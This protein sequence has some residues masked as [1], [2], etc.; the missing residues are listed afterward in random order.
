TGAIYIASPAA[1]PAPEDAAYFVSWMDRVIEAVEARG[2]WNDD[3]QKA[4]THEYLE[5][6]RRKFLEKSKAGSAQ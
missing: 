1:P 4:D 2:G 6:A 3:R 5:A